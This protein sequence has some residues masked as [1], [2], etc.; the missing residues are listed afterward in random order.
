MNDPRDAYLPVKIEVFYAYSMN[1]SLKVVNTIPGSS[2]QEVKNNQ[3]MSFECKESRDTFTVTFEIMYPQL[4]EQIVTVKFSEGKRATDVEYTQ[5][6]SN[7]V[8]PHATRNGGPCSRI[9]L[10]YRIR[11]VPEPTDPN[12]IARIIDQS[13]QAD[14]KTERNL[15]DAR[16]AEVMNRLGLLGGVVA[17]LMICCIIV[18]A[19]KK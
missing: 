17:I 8:D 12:E 9:V 5:Y 16:H 1:F 15:A 7:A 11:T 14:A 18:I 10:N 2:W 4:V 13:R 19:L 3:Y 6:T